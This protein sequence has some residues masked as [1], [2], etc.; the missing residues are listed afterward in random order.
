MLDQQLKTRNTNLGS[1]RNN[2]NIPVDPSDDFE[3]KNVLTIKGL[4]DA[5]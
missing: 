5:H 2:S 3:F 1:I 4:E